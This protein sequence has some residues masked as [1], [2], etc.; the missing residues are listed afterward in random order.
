M[1]FEPELGLVRVDDELVV[2]RAA[3]GDER[4]VGTGAEPA[5]GGGDQ[6]REGVVRQQGATVVDRVRRWV[7]D[8]RCRVLDAVLVA[9][10][11]EDLADL[12]L[13]VALAAVERDDRGGV[14]DVELV[15]A[16]VA[17][18]RDPPVECGV[19]V[20]A[21]DRVADL[22]ADDAALVAVRVAVQQGHEGRLISGLVVDACTPSQLVGAAASSPYIPSV[23]MHFTA[24]SRN[25]SSFGLRVTVPGS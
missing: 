4:S 22:V 3:G 1:P 9:L 2:A 6:H 8:G 20:D 21:L 23:S 16:V 17:V 25:R 11:A 19:V 13:V 14:V 24:R 12:E 7:L 10:G 5:A 15:V 18:H